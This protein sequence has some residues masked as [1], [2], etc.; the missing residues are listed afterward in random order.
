MNPSS[1]ALPAAGLAA[2]ASRLASIST[3][4]G[5]RVSGFPDDDK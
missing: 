3:G 2:C 5:V 4:E 1:L